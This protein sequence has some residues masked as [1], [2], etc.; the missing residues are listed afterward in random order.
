MALE[1][2]LSMS[3][4]QAMAGGQAVTGDQGSVKRRQHIF[5]LTLVAAKAFYGYHAQDRA[6]VKISL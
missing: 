3:T 4:A 6:W 1:A 2:V 5:D